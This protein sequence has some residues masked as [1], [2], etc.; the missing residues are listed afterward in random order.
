MGG[1][2]EHGISSARE[3]HWSDV[4]YGDKVP[5]Q[6]AGRFLELVYGELLF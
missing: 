3:F 2:S 4:E 6:Q 1:C 5:F